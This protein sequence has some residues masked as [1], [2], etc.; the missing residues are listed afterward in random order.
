M[1]RPIALGLLA[2]LAGTVIG[3][4]AVNGLMLRI[5]LRGRTL[6]STSAPSTAPTVLKRFLQRWAT[7]TTIL[8][9]W[10][11]PSRTARIPIALTTALIRGLLSKICPRKCP[12]QAYA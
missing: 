3:A 11:E 1:N 7:S 8:P 5:T 9:D 6:P 2:L 12:N 4:T 10:P